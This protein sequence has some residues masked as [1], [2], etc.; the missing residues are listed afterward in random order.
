MVGSHRGRFNGRSRSPKVPDKARPTAVHDFF[1]NATRSYT[2]PTRPLMTPPRLQPDLYSIIPLPT[3]SLLDQ[4]DFYV[5]STP[6]RSTWSY[7]GLAVQG[8]WSI[9]RKEVELIVYWSVFFIP[10]KL[11]L[12][13]IV[14][15]VSRSTRP[16]LNQ[17]PITSR[18]LLE[19]LAS[20]SRLEFLDMSK[21]FR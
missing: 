7:R 15:N 21:I 12:Y 20:R 10:T 18:W 19:R 14:K 3:R 11:D 5:I 1:P 4:L 8:S 17:Y 2:T 13:T 6:T 16:L 9:G